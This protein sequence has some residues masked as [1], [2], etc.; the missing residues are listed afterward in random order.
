M[1][2]Q[3]GVIVVGGGAA[4]MVA[5]IA[6]ARGGAAV[7]LL[8][9][10]P[11]VGKK[12]LA[13]GNGRCNLANANLE[14]SRYHG[15]DPAFAR[16]A[17]AAFG[18]Q[19]TLRFFADLGIAAREEEA[20][21]IFPRSGQAASVLDLLRHEMAGLGVE[22]RCESPVTRLAPR[23]GLWEVSTVDAALRCA[24][25]VL[26]SGGRAS[27]QLGSNGS[28]YDLVRPLG[29]RLIQPFPA[30]TRIRVSSP[31]LRH[32][33]GVKIAGRATLVPAGPEHHRGDRIVNDREDAACGE[34]LFTETGLSG[35][36]ILDLSRR[37]GE[38]A[39]SGLATL[40]RLDLCPEFAPDELRALLRERFAGRRAAGGDQPRPYDGSRFT[41]EGSGPSRNN[42]P[43]SVGEGSSPSRNNDPHSVG[44]GLIPSHNNDPHSVGEGLIPSRNNDPHS[45]GEGL[46]P[47]RDNDPHSVGEGLILSRNNDPHSVGEGLIPSRNNDPHSA[48][49]RLIPSRTEM[50]AELALVGFIN[51]RLIGPV[52]KVAGIPDPTVPAAA[53]GIP[54]IQAIA[55]VLKGWRFDVTGTDSW[56]EAQVTAGGVDVTGVHPATLESRLAAGLYFAGEVLDIDGDC[57]GFNLQWAWSSGHLAGMGA[58]GRAGKS[59]R[60]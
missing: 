54:A 53:L 12:L 25:V 27:P 26:A 11:R 23:R 44:E 38:R 17:L 58:A 52:L 55:A 6:A 4:G 10:M 51:K 19:Q 48:G 21:K 3:G 39:Q 41:G 1:G 31:F 15:A 40:L 22:T 59:L 8:E 33:K 60:Q 32:L 56:T 46:I 43:H 9:R 24:A 20:G 18:L 47:S 2:H 7:T 42:D 29:H 30:L 28:G 13:T 50:S 49:E 35:P 16:A 37:A 34:I 57:G 45:V 14:L 5:A 36:P